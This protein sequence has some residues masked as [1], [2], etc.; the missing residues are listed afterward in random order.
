MRRIYFDT[1]FTGLKKET[2]WDAYVIS[3]I[4]ERYGL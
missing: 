3:K 1:K 4:G 2:E